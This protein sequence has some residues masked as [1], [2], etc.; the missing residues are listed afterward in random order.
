MTVLD[1]WF[2]VVSTLPGFHGMD[3]RVALRLP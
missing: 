2:W 1:H 3:P